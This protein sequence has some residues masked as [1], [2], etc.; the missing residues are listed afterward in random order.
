MRSLFALFR[1]RVVPGRAAVAVLSAALTVFALSCQEAPAENI[2]NQFY[3]YVYDPALPAADFTLTNQKGQPFTLSSTRG[4]VVLMTFLYTRCIYDC[5]YIAVKMREAMKIL[6]EDAKKIKMVAVSVDPERDTVS[7]IA[8]YSERLGLY[9]SW[10]FVT[11]SLA[12][13]EK[14]WTDYSITVKKAVSA[15]E[16]PAATNAPGSIDEDHQPAPAISTLG[17]TDADIETAAGTIKDF[18]G[19]YEVTHSIQFCLIDANGKIV[20][21]LSPDATPVELARDLRNVLKL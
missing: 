3:G 7:E 10:D 9:D 6:G 20:V 15:A 4:S 13:M 1:A 5:P 12:D 19:G 11:G 21:A 17:L 14:V 8:E 16:T 18:G 2:K